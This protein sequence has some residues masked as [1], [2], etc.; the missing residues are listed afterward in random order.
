MKDTKNIPEIDKKW[1]RFQKHFNLQEKQIE[2][3][4]RYSLMLQEWN[5]KI[6][7]TAISDPGD[8]I[9]SHFQDSLMLSHFVEINDISM[10]ADVGAGAGFP[11]LPLKICYPHLSIVLIEV[12]QK[13][14][15][16]LHKIIDT[17]ELSNVEICD[18]DW[19]TFLRS[20]DYPIELFCARASVSVEELI[21]MFSP[22]SPYHS[23][24]LVYWASKNWV[25]PEFVQPYV[26]RQ[27]QYT[28]DN[29]QRRYIFLQSPARK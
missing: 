29:K 27:E 11:S 22:I 21:R 26:C 10:L 15:Q 8:I 23:A 12:I 6:N 18:L 4:Q 5:K 13:K 3:F 17:L 7:L 9:T 1:K 14:I 20:T 24:Q 2:K 19:R 28:I 25:I 16:F